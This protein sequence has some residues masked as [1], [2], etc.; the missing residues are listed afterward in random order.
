MSE[1][2]KLLMFGDQYKTENVGWG[3]P[4]GRETGGSGQRF[5]KETK[6]CKAAE[7]VGDCDE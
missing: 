6:V 2:Q 1:N 4:V 7:S 3:T 5:E